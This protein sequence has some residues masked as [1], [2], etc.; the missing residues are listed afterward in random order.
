MNALARA[1]DICVKEGSGNPYADLGLP[2]AKEML[3][4]AGLALEIE[5]IIRSRRLTRQRAAELLGVEKGKL[6]D[7]MRGN[8]RNIS[9]TMMT[10]CLNQL[11]SP[12]NRDREN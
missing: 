2:D 10:E 3:V 5:K 6:A 12:W 4:K 9:Q 8:F 7:L 1:E 11:R